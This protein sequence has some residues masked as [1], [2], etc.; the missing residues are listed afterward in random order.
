MQTSQPPRLISKF[1]K[2]IGLLVLV[3]LS[4]WLATPAIALSDNV[5]LIWQRS[6]N[7]VEIG[8]PALPNKW[9]FEASGIRVNG[10]L[11]VMNE[12]DEINGAV[13]IRYAETIYLGT[14]NHYRNGIESHIKGYKTIYP[15]DDAF[16]SIAGTV[17]I[18]AQNTKDWTNINYQGPGANV[19]GS[20]LFIENGA[21]GTLNWGAGYFTMGHFNGMKT[22]QWDGLYVANPNWNGQGTP[23]LLLN[24]YG[25]RIAPQTYGSNNW[26]FYADESNDPSAGTSYFGTG[27]LLRN[28]R[29][30]S[31]FDTTGVRR[32]LF[33]LDDSNTLKI[34][35]GSLYNANIQ[36]NGTQNVIPQIDNASSLGRA[37]RRWDEI[38]GVS[39]RA[40]DLVFKNDWYFTETTNGI[41]L[42][43]PDDTV[44][45]EWKSDKKATKVTTKKTKAELIMSD[46][47]TGKGK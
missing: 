14:D 2:S 11:G 45:Q 44:A 4:V 20:E 43:R 8:N 47:A 5:S 23:G 38:W 24:N 46:N 41:A 31:A 25:V 37:D 36:I 30:M 34:G 32:S 42:M 22:N 3:V 26:A 39:V 29:A 6:D 28:G 15:F 19:M 16:V 13:G 33:Y 27:A 7:V 1:M 12:P 35:V 40:G 17:T 9:G 21:T 10:H 18:K